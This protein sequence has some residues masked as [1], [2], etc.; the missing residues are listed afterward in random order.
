MPP[1]APA[2]FGSA[3]LVKVVLKITHTAFLSIFEAHEMTADIRRD[4]DDVIAEFLYA[5]DAWLYAYLLSFGADAE[6]LAPAHIRE[7]MKKRFAAGME[8]YNMT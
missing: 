8:K 1:P 5:E 7:G 3:P 2:Q 6:V 4:G